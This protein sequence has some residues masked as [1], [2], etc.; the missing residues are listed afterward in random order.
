MGA[1]R[2]EQIGPRAEWRLPDDET[3]KRTSTGAVERYSV[4]LHEIGPPSIGVP[5]ILIRLRK[6]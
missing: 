3:I 4:K 1:E 6:S 5:K 2:K